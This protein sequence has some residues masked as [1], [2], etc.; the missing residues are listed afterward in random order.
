MAQSAY[1]KQK[2]NELFINMA[3]RNSTEF[4]SKSYGRKPGLHTETMVRKIPAILQTGTQ[5]RHHSINEK[6]K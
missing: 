6:K 2:Y 5:N 4:R 3:E 1:F